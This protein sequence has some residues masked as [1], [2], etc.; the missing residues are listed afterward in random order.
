MRLVSVSI[1]NFRQHKQTHIEFY[2][3]VTGI[4]G[5]NGSGKTTI[6]E[7]MAWA[8][9]GKPAVRGHNDSLRSKAAEGNE[10]VE[11]T[12]V[13][14]LDPHT[15]SVTR[16][17]DT[18]GKTHAS[19]SVDGVNT[20][21]GF[22]T[23]TKAIE[24]SLGMNY[25]AFFTSFFTAQKE[26][27]FMRGLDGRERATAISRMLG[28]ER[29][30]KAR[31]KANKDRLDLDR[32][33]S[34]IEH[35]LGSAEEIK[36]RKTESS[37]EV[38]SAKKLLAAEERKENEAKKD[39]DR[40][41]PLR[42][43]SEKKARLAADYSKRIDL[44]TAER[45]RSSERIKELEAEIADLAAKDKELISLMPQVEEFHAAETE[46]KM[47]SEL[48]KHESFR[49][50]T[51]G[52]LLILKSDITSLQS[53]IADLAEYPSEATL[54]EEALD[55]LEK[56][57]N[58]VN[59]KIE[60]ESDTLNKILS[61]SQAELEQ[62]LSYRE[63]TLAKRQTIAD[64]GSE[65][66]CP[67]CERPLGE[68]HAKVLAGFDKQI[69]S[70]DRRTAEIKNHLAKH[71]QEPSTLLALRQL[72]QTLESKRNETMQ[73][74][75]DI[76]SRCAEL[77]KRKEEY[78]KK[79]LES[80]KLEKQL[81]SLPSG[82]DQER[83]DELRKLG[84]RLKP[85]RDRSVELRSALS[86]Q[87][88]VENDLKREKDSFARADNNIASL[89]ASIVELQFSQLEH[90]TLIREYELA[91]TTLASA[92]LTAERA[93]G[94]LK[95]AQNAL[96]NALKDEKNYK[97]K[98]TE[99]NEKRRTRL[100]LQ[101]LADA[102]DKLRDDLNNRTAPELAIT[103]SDLL[104]EMTD[105]RYTAIR[106]SDVYE[107]QII[108]DG[109]P[110]PIISGGEEDVV[111]LALRLAVSKMIAERAGHNLSLLA[112]DEVFGSLDDIRRDNV[113][114]QL[115]MLKSRFEQIV[116]ITHI[117]AIHD[118]VDNCVWVDYEESTK[119]SVIR[120]KNDES[121]AALYN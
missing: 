57:I 75:A 103:A 109:E 91:Q 89:Q 47:L 85:A 66:K 22:M 8:L 110:K 35:T 43:T 50:E 54:I 7:A 1:K 20:Q 27:E 6:L 60:K 37:R 100:H 74:R 83:F 80:Q 32:E 68:E 55:D 58:G 88:N 114:S 93:R 3:G 21:T 96:D 41:H 90:E 65:G 23:V 111:N 97:T 78:E 52:R 53:Q 59:E 51:N 84:Y 44:D 69:E 24:K 30:L 42:D 36:Q 67:T 82:F 4:I 49:A 116:L 115:Q 113:V 99:L 40:L 56:Q 101:T 76:A 31:D 46:Y 45:K 25:Q 26:L 98:E 120:T 105:G 9:Y 11:V 92:S 16:R 117:E 118:A 94:E 70:M 102:L 63:E 104:A 17:L 34:A 38:A 95:V 29:I 2:P 107:A 5:K 39:Y 13:F 62:L 121:E 71:Q 19:L 77:P 28:Y 79:R 12:L 87:E 14:T 33:I 112:L 64:A 86:R 15:Y 72:K 61:K 106:V 73:K 81:T 48:Q 119:T 18:S 108:D 10:S